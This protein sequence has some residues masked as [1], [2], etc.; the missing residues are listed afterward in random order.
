[1]A[2]L[3]FGVPAVKGVEFGQGFQLSRLKGSESNDPIGL[4][5]GKPRTVSHKQGGVVGGITDGNLVDFRVAFKPTS[6]LILPQ[7]TVN[8]Q[9]QEETEVRTQ[10]RHDPCIVPRAVV[11]VENAAAIVVLDLLLQRLGELGFHGGP[12]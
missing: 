11:V 12:S 1:M 4:V 5:D 2:Q 3:M 8:L 9:T 10:G 7:H 6:S